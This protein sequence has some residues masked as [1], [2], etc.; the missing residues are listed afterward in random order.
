MSAP[1]P[2]PTAAPTDTAGAFAP[3][4]VGLRLD[5]ITLVRGPTR[6][7]EDLTLHLT[8]QRIGLIGDNG[9]GKS[10]L[11]RLLCGLD[12]P[13]SGQVTRPAGMSLGMMFQNPDEQIIF[14]TVA[15][16][17][18]LSL[19]ASGVSRQAARA[20]ARD[21]LQARGMGAWAER[22]IGSLSQGQRQ[23]LCWL[24]LL[25]AEHDVLLL[26][27]PFSSLDLPGQARLERD[28]AQAA[29]QVIVS[30][31]VLHHIR[32]FERVIWLDAGRVRHDGQ[33]REVC[34]AYEADVAQRALRDR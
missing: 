19:Q 34:A 30:T 27:E 33:G 16:E 9:A 8:Q 11:F 5:H 15:E 7:F 12:Q 2:H 28:I 23:H 21:W 31:H 24:A 22:A 3:A 18:G 29:Q 4:G 13:L 1:L 14:P 26:D 6:V 10:S 25:M 32:H 17:L 20:Q